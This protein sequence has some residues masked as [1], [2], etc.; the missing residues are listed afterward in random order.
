M[1]TPEFFD[2]RNPLFDWPSEPVPPRLISIG[3]ALL[4]NYAL[5]EGH[6]MSLPM[7]VLALSPPPSLSSLGLRVSVGLPWLL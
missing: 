1:L 3:D 6:A 7:T 2:C 5:N 4:R